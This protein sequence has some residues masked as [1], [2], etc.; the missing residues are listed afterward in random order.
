MINVGNKRQ[1]KGI[2]CSKYTR[3]ESSRKIG[4]VNILLQE[5]VISLYKYIRRKNY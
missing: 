2:E 5:E 4:C 3:K 1:A